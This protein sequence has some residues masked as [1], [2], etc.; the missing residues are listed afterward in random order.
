MASASEALLSVENLRKN[1]GGVKALDG[2]TFS[3]AKGELAGL[4][5]PNGSGK[6]TAFNLLTGVL[7]PS[8]G[9]IRFR[10]EPV[11]G[12]PPERN[13]RLGMARTFQNI[14][15]FRELPVSDNVMVGVHMR[16]GPGFVPTILRLPSARKAEDSIRER[17][18]TTLE[19]LGLA[20]RAHDIVGS[21]PY[22]DQR[23]VE[24]ARALATEPSLLLLDEPTAGMNPHETADLGET[25]R[26]LHG[27]LGITTLLVEHDMKMVMGLCRHIIVVHQGVVLASGVPE[28]IQSNP[29]VIEAYLGRRRKGTNAAS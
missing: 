15:L 21:L 2:V 28:L 16:H 14:R 8:S 29:K 12:N 11:G 1:F 10:S 6:T 23:K 4:I 9:T 19:V 17:A 22:G 20:R 7:K 18:M 27:E 25:I 3:L 24:F 5:G 13:A 26:R